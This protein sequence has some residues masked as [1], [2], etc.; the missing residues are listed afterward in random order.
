M[1]PWVG[2]RGG[3][4]SSS[5]R[6]NVGND[7]A[8][9]VKSA[10]ERTLLAMGM[11]PGSSA[12][13]PQFQVYVDQLS[14]QVPGDQYVSKVALKASIRVVVRA[15]GKNYQGSYTAREERRV[16]KALSDEENR[17]W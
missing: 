5:N 9:A 15:D 12:E 11:S 13:A 10:V 14:Y 8:S 7:V 6:I 4:Y 16:L 1:T 3:V 17:R 2:T